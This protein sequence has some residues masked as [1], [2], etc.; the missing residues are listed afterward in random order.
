MS[1]TD[2]SQKIY[3]P[4]RLNQMHFWNDSTNISGQSSKNFSSAGMQNIQNN[5]STF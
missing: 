2:S 3:I 4:I 5:D 1:N